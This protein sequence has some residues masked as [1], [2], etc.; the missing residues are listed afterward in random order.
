MR[1]AVGLVTGKKHQTENIYAADTVLE[2][3]V[4]LNLSSVL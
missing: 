1:I 2:L 3:G 4:P